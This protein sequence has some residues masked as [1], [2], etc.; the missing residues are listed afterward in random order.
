VRIHLLQLSD[1]SDAASLC[2]K[3]LAILR[4][5]KGD[6]GDVEL[7]T[8][9]FSKTINVRDRLRRGSSVNGNAQNERNENTFETVTGHGVVP[10]RRKE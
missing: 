6:A 4:D 1:G 3:R 8:D 5:G 10:G 7:R 2:E 9:P